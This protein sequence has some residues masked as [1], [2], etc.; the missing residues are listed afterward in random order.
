MGKNLEEIKGLLA[1]HRNDLEMQHKVRRIGVF[2]SFVRGEATDQSD[3]DILVEFGEV[4]DLFEFID[5]GDYLESILHRKVDL[6]TKGALKPF[7]KDKILN[8]VIY[9]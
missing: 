9:V 2:G 8:E 1:A 5:V 3:I 4:T 6:V 7:L